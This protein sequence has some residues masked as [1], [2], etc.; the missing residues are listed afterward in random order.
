MCAYSE[1]K[2]KSNL[3]VTFEAEIM[4]TSSTIL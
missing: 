4:E 2:I 3:G 1:T